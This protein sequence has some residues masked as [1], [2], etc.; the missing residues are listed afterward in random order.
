MFDKEVLDKTNELLPEGI[1]IF[2]WVRVTGGFDSKKNCDAR[3]Y[4]YTLRTE[5]LRPSKKHP[6][7]EQRDSWKFDSEEEAR[8]R[9]LLMKFQGTHKY[10]NFTKGGKPGNASCTRYIK[11][12]KLSSPYTVNGM[13]FVS[14]TLH[15]QSFIL[16][17]IR[18]MIG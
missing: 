11:E 17:Q 9:N 8:F 3:T 1:R 4:E 16:H 13:E 18:K 7:Y 15:G 5:C 6:N 2:D 10:H 14:V 12:M